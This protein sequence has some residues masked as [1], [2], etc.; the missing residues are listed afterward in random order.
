MKKENLLL[1]LAIIFLLV[2]TLC[3]PALAQEK[4][5][6]K[7]YL[8]GGLGLGIDWLESSEIEDDLVT[9]FHIENV[10]FPFEL[11]VHGGYSNIIQLE[12]RQNV[13]GPYHNIEKPGVAL[14]EMEYDYNEALLKINPLFKNYHKKPS[15]L[16][17]V[18]GKGEIEYLDKVG[19]G[20]K[21]DSTI[22]GL[23]WFFLSKY[24]SG[25]YGLKI[26]QINLDQGS[27]PQLSGKEYSAT[28]IMLEVSIA[29]GFGM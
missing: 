7:I 6:P 29:F 9:G 25:S 1:K 8:H 12:Y 24:M 22:F 20:W 10:G 2:L 5:V 3:M 15:S 21:G 27:I 11:L 19:D 13:H 26:N 28:N 14:I 23:E 18:I 17:L 16:F 4:I